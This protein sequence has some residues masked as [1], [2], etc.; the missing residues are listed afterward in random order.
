MDYFSKM[1]RLP[2]WMI[3]V[4]IFL[5][6]VL[7]QYNFF[8]GLFLGLFVGLWYFSIAY[9]LNIK[10]P[11]DV[12]LSIN[13]FIFIS[14]Y[15]YAYSIFAHFFFGTGK[16]ETNMF[17]FVFPFHIFAMYCIFYSFFFI[18]KCLVSI[19][20]GKSPKFDRLIGSIFML[21]FFPIGI[22]FILP[23]IKRALDVNTL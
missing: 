6:L 8:L 1:A 17:L 5:P 13:W 14:V 22:W 19:E 10:T 2:N 21:W 16:I 18:A 12:N 11:T 15:A 3:I 7:G 4:S 20:D 23:R 9:E